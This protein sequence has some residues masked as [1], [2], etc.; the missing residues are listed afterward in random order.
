MAKEFSIV[1][2]E[3]PRIDAYERVTGRA[4][5][6]GDYQLPNMLYARVLR[7]PHPHAKI[8]SIDTSKA[9]KLPGVK[10]IIHN[11]N[12]QVPWA[13]GGLTQKRLIF[14]NPVRFVGDAV[15]AV[16]ATDRYI[17]EDALSLVEIKYEELPYVL[18]AAEALKPDAPKIYPKGNLSVGD[19][20]VS[21]PFTEQWGDLEKGFK[22]ADKVFEDTYITKHVNNAQ[23]ERR[24]SVARWDGGKLTVWAST[25]GVSNARTD[26]ARD[27]GLPLSK[28]QVICKYMGGGFGN[29]VPV[30][31]GYVVAI[32]ASIVTG[33]INGT[34]CAIPCA[35]AAAR[36]CPCSSTGIPPTRTCRCSTSTKVVFGKG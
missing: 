33:R 13:S 32:V 25:Q 2:K 11:K 31:P 36:P 15:A 29:K 34:P 24:A 10:A 16:V 7:S 19:G 28:V 3:T 23:I 9:E 5:Y 20:R 17:A 18:D 27:L 30:Y 8:I 4:Q 6:A 1:G 21:A 26:I 12:T 35:R 14:N 22:E